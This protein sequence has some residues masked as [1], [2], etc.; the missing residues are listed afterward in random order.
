MQSVV[1][2]LAS[3]TSTVSSRLIWEAVSEFPSSWG[4][5][6]SHCVDD[7]ICLSIHLSMDELFPLFG[8]DESWCCEHL[9]TSFCADALFSVSGVY[10]GVKLVDQM[11]ALSLAFWG[12]AKLFAKVAAPF[13]IPAR[14]GQGSSFSTFSP[15]L[16]LPNSGSHRPTRVCSSKSFLA[17]VHLVLWSVCGYFLCI[18]VRKEFNFFLCTS[19]SYK[20][21]CPNT[22]EKTILCPIRCC[23]T[24]I[25]DQLATHVRV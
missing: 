12:P 20:I 18:L 24:F 17:L 23:G 16:S 21:S 3:F 9:C 4:W 6:I 11:V 7:C 8:F 19:V 22:A 5:F 15:T 10:L 2:F 14:Q 1:L 13:H 25:E